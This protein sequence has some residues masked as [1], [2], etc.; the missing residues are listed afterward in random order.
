MPMHRPHTDYVDT[1]NTDRVPKAQRA[2]HG[3][4]WCRPVKQLGCYI[5]DGFTCLYC[6]TDLRHA[7]PNGPQGA[8]LDHVVPNSQGGDNSE[9]NLITACRTCNS[10]RRDRD[11][12]EFA[13]PGAHHRILLAMATPINRKL[14]R[15]LLAD[16]PC[17]GAE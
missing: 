7:D 16:V 11:W 6:G 9:A 12:R 15:S 2:Y 13:P 3:K 14:A 17:D 4:G 10:Q 8:S 5:R 1:T